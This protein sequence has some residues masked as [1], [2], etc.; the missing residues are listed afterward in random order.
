MK[1]KKR[2]VFIIAEIGNLHN[3]SLVLAKRFIKEA[4]S[5]G[6]DAIKFQTHIFEAES[7]EDAP[8]P[9]YFNKESRKSYFKRTAFSLKEWKGLKSFA[10]KNGI[11]FMS[12]VF[13]L[14]ALNLMEKVGLKRYKVP[15]GEITN[16]KLLE[17]IAKTKKP[18]ILS[19]GMNNWAELDNAV[20]TL[21]ANGCKDLTILQCASIYPCPAERAGLNLIREIKKRYGVTVG[22]SDHS[23]GFYAS[24]AAVVMGAEVIEKHFSLSKNLYGS[25]AR[26]S[27]KGKEFGTFIKEIRNTQKAINSKINKNRLSEDIKKMKIIFE[28]S[29]VASKKISKG[30]IIKIDMLAFK[31]PGDGMRADRYKEVVGKMAKLTI[32]PNTK[33]QK[34][35]LV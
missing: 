14:E 25:D 31:K 1:N 32:L 26:H 30:K 29:I 6:A 12:S 35:M 24:I 10:E 7:L 20:F 13:S 9:P 2:R 28:K 5:A 33:I 23:L 8:N 22:L 18:V 27:L 3:G 19:S 16:L 34:E 15:S 4:A 11:E 17:A 21:K